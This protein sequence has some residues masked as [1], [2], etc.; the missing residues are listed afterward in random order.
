MDKKGENHFVGTAEVNGQTLIK[1]MIFDSTK[2]TVSVSLKT[3]N[4]AASA[5]DTFE[6]R[7]GTQVLK[8]KSSM[9]TPAYEGTEFFSIEDGSE[10]RERLDIE[11]PYEQTFSKTTLTS[12]GSQYFSIAL[13]DKSPIIPTNKLKYNPKEQVAYASVYHQA[14]TNNNKTDIQFIGFVGPKKYDVLKELGPNFVSLINYGMFSILSKPM[15]SMLKWLYGMLENWGVAI[16]LS[17]NFYP[18]NSITSN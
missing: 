5:N 1:E 9:F 17:N 6:T 12:I 4:G 3:L 18:K 13:N 15:L 11:K 8:V 14:A 16:I 10:E 2:Y 7:L